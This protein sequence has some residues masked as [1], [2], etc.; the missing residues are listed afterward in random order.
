MLSVSGRSNISSTVLA[1]HC[2]IRYL[3]EYDNSNQGFQ[4]SMVD[5]AKPAMAAQVKIQPHI[6]DKDKG[7]VGFATERPSRISIRMDE[8][9][10]NDINIV[11]IG[12]GDLA[13]DASISSIEPESRNLK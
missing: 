1:K 11:G 10:S 9:Q 13:D 4:S 12:G 2:N 5:R 7:G 6:S 3:R 8:G